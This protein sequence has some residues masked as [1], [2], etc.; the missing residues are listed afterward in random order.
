MRSRL[1]IVASSA[2][3]A[4]FTALAIAQEP[5]T[6]PGGMRVIDREAPN[7]THDH[8]LYPHNAKHPAAPDA[9][10]FTTSRRDAIRLP[11]PAE[12]DAFSFVVFG[13]R[14]GG[15]ADG[16]NVLADAVRDVNL[17]E[18][19]LVMTVGDLVQGYTEDPEYSVQAREY[20]TIMNK[21]IPPWFPVAG[22]HDIYW[23]DKDKS[24][25]KRPAR[26][27]ESKFETH[28]GPLW[29]AFEHKK[30]WFIVLFSDEGDAKTGAKG[31]SKP[32]MQQM[33]DEQF[34]WLKETL[35]RAKGADH[36]FLFLHH[37]R[38][39][40]S[41]SSHE[42]YG[43]SWDRVHK[44]L[45]EAG[46]V[47][48]VF[49]G[50]VHHMRYDAKD[51]I[52]Y[53]TLATTGAGLK[54]NNPAAGLL[55]HYHVVTV[56]KN[57]V[58]MAAFPVNSALDVR[59]MT[60]DLTEQT[61]RLTAANPAFDKPVALS[62]DGSADG[63]V[64]VRITN[65]TSRPVE[66]T[67]VPDSH[68]SRWV[69]APDHQHKT[70]AAGEAATIPFQVR[71]GV[72]P[73]DSTFRPLELVVDTDYL[74]PTHRYAIP[75]RRLVLPLDLSSFRGSPMAL[76][77]DGKS[78]PIVP[79]GLLKL[80]GKQFTLEGRFRARAFEGRQSLL[81]KMQKGGYGI[82]VG[83]AGRL[84]ANFFVGDQYLHVRTPETTRLETNRWYHVAEVFDG[85]ELRFYLD[86]RLIG[87][88]AR[89]GTLKD[90]DFPL[91]LGGDVGPRG[92]AIDLLNG[93]LDAVRVSSTARYAGDSFTPAD[94]HAPD[95]QTLL[96]LNFDHQVGPYLVD[97]SPKGRLLPTTRQAPK[98][99]P[100]GAPGSR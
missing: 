56:R 13:D 27:N 84:A 86:G 17:L 91:I 49:G 7:L 36:V 2:A 85:R 77:L 82:A 63:M 66:Y 48:A 4:V 21:L 54:D 55:H 28:F 31:F 8:H 90:N 52:E 23:R 93:E 12:K 67:L 88:A 47:T 3:F 45:A 10:R 79:A 68:D 83:A 97:E 24:G 25:D 20:K 11:L 15:P 50:H 95:A 99:V 9:A 19:D 80:P 92:A 76:S 30:S 98:F 59:E 44:A 69:A 73:I 71:R 60:G 42:G 100:V 38:W 51:G 58:A 70:L 40:G 22:N 6:R 16:V 46:N 5:A 62:S 14:T 39:L 41:R 34:A 53:V 94:R 26:E 33:S 37:P 74:G 96:L 57:Q 1:I 78:A 61:G 89:E 32:S 43:D 29:Y 87:K 64:N 65:P 18:P 72:A 75:T 81:G 35:A